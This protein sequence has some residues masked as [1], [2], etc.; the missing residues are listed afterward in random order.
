MKTNA[1]TNLG[2]LV[3]SAFMSFALLFLATFGINQL[4]GAV[5]SWRG[6]A[7]GQEEV[8]SDNDAIREAK[9]DYLIQKFLEKYPTILHSEEYSDGLRIFSSDR[10]DRRNG[11]QVGRRREGIGRQILDVIFHYDAPNGAKTNGADSVDIEC[12]MT[13]CGPMPR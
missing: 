6:C 2:R 13:R 10:Q 3:F 11:W 12:S 9:N 7:A 4:T 8:S 5:E 1:Q